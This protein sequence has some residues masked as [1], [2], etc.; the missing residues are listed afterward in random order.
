VFVSRPVGRVTSLLRKEKTTF[1]IGKFRLANWNNERAARKE[2]IRAGKL[3]ALAVTTAAR[4]E[5]LPDVPA[6]SEFVLSYEASA[7]YGIGRATQNA[8]EIIDKLNKA[9]NA[10]LDSKLKARL[11]D[12]GG[13]GASRFA[14]RFRQTHRGRD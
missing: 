11:A 1:R 9:I 7:W 14:R 3:R 6:V 13:A 8:G 10:A 12:L 2:F 4:S 5:A